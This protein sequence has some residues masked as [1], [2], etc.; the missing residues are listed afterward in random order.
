MNS[1]RSPRWL[2]SVASASIVVAGARAASS[3]TSPSECGVRL[4]PDD[5]SEAW[6]TAVRT[7]E[8]RVHTLSAS[9]RDCRE[10]VVTIG[11]E[12][13]Q[14]EFTSVAGRHAVRF[15]RT[16]DELEPT[17]EALLVTIPNDVEP[18]AATPVAKPEATVDA[19][20]A[21]AP[22]TTDSSSRFVLGLAAGTRAGWPSGFV[23][24]VVSG[25]A[26]F[27]A[28]HWEIGVFAAWEMSYTSATR[29]LPAGVQLSAFAAGVSLARRAPLSESIS[30]VLGGHL[31]GAVV[32]EEGGEMTD[33]VGGTQAEARVGLTTALVL[34]TTAS[35]HFRPS[36]GFD[37][38]PTRLRGRSDIDPRL[39][40][41]PKWGISLMLG[42]ES[43]AL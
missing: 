23:T 30:L 8:A 21:A 11:G 43:E 12:G 4:V 37:L 15:A 6:R 31:G 40:T 26:G 25:A 14:I 39:P 34:P 17:I 38:V 13:A 33:G 10:I 16:A 3:A 22:S 5:A 42:V 18:P 20:S 27:A 36:I 7:V 24:P 28:R 2:T 19:R 32:T 1:W 9:S 29:P 41:P 35:V